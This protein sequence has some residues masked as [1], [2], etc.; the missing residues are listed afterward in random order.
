MQDKNLT[1]SS[2]FPTAPTAQKPHQVIQKWHIIYPDDTT[3][4]LDNQQF[5]SVKKTV[6]HYDSL[7]AFKKLDTRIKK[8][9]H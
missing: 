9:N 6:Y 4:C 8:L 5:K 1:P 3:L 2:S 7:K